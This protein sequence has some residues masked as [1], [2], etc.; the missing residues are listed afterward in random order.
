MSNEESNK[1]SNER[2][3][4]PWSRIAIDNGRVTPE[5][6]SR[7]FFLW[8]SVKTDVD[9]VCGIAVEGARAPDE[10]VTVSV[11]AHSCVS[12]S[13]WGKQPGVKC[14]T[15]GSKSWTASTLGMGWVSIGSSFVDRSCKV[16]TESISPSGS[17]SGEAKCDIAP[18]FLPQTFPSTGY[19]QT[20]W[21]PQLERWHFPTW[22]LMQICLKAPSRWTS[23]THWFL[24]LDLPEP[25]LPLDFPWPLPF[26]PSNRGDAVCEVGAG[27]ALRTRGRGWRRLGRSWR[28]FV[29]SCKQSSIVHPRSMSLAITV[30][31][32]WS[33]CWASKTL[34][35]R[36]SPSYL[37]VKKPMNLWVKALRLAKCAPWHNAMARWVHPHGIVGHVKRR[38]IIK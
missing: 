4:C 10:V 16:E 22:Y 32:F 18:W 8:E 23:V 34:G 37:A 35:L 29:I 1:I 7:F 15:G 21:E 27:S 19:A 30:Q 2:T 38:R 9:I 5:Q 12:R 11:I 17:Q 20:C 14:S 33:A 26:C 25:C 28:R 31:I 13:C 24:P 3:G 6:I 36:R